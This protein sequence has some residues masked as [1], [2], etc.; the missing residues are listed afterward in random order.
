MSCTM[1][2]VNASVPIQITSLTDP[3]SWVDEFSAHAE[4]RG[5]L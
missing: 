3:V 4:E 1:Q 5:F 2:V